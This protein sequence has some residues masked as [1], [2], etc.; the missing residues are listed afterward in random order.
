MIAKAKAEEAEKIKSKLEQEKQREV[1][2]IR[3]TEEAKRKEEE[4]KRE[5]ELKKEQAKKLVDVAPP[6]A[7]QYSSVLSPTPQVQQ[8]P[9]GLYLR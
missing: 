8:P 2:E 7:A 1:E 3:R 4:R 9:S 5:Q 6:P